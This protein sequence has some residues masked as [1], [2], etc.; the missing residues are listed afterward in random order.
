[1]EPNR[2]QTDGQHFSLLLY[3]I[4]FIG[5]RNAGVFHGWLRGDVKEFNVFGLQTGAPRSGFI[6][7]VWLLVATSLLYTNTPRIT[8]KV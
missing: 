8:N 3:Y 7:F 6:C 2:E 1:M 4:L 5:P